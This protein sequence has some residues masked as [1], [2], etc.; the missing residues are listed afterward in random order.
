VDSSVPPPPPR[1]RN[2][3]R[4]WYLVAA[5]VLTWFIGVHGLNNGF[6]TADFLR[7]GT[8]PDSSTAA[9]HAGTMADVLE[10][11]GLSAQGAMLSHARTIFP[12]SVAE[13]ILSGFLVVASGLAMSGRRGARSLALQAI[14]A[15]ALWLIAW[16]VLTP[17]LRAAYLEGFLRAMDTV[18]LAPEQRAALANPGYLLWAWRIKLIVFD[19]G[20]LGL[21]ALALTR[22]RTRT[23]F[24]AVARA[25]ETTEEP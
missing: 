24:A 17:M 13:V 15:N 20:L 18:T 23:Y 4:P 6:S 7:K 22:T 12:L 2:K 25:A 14:V 3:L 21:G 8:L 19:L 11:A 16:F 9:L 5:M 1:S 10:L